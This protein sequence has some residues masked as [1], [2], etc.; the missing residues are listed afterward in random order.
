MELINIPW[1]SRRIRS[2]EYFDR[3]ASKWDTMCRE[4]YTESLREKILSRIYPEPG[5]IIADI[6]SGTGFVSEGLKDSPASVIAIDHS[7]KM[8]N[9]M[10]VKFKDSSKFDYRKGDANHLPA[11]DN[12]VNY[13]LVNMYLH[14]VEDPPRAIAEI[15]RILTRGGVMVLTDMENHSHE[16]L[17]EEDHDR[18]LGFKHADIEQWMAGA[19]FIN[20]TVESIGEYCCIN[21]TRTERNAEIKIFLAR[22]KKP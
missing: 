6:G 13:A 2:R 16:Y 10:K 7:K 8:L 11:R 17:L 19:G 12:F 18:W 21:S 20:V 3:V 4:L 15:F 5:H 1:K 14:H 9:L 22:G